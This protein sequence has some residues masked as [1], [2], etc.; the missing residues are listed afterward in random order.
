VLNKSLLL[1]D[2]SIFLFGLLDD[3]NSDSLLHVS[4]GESSEWWEG[5]ESFDNHWLG[6]GHSDDTGIS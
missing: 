2:S 3:T 5:S 4:D 1:G 6:W